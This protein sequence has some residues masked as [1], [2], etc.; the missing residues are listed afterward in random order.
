MFLS[1]KHNTAFTEVGC[2]ETPFNLR[3]ALKFEVQV[4]L[5]FTFLVFRRFRKIAKKDC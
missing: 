3:V 2:A 5:D 4:N 1:D